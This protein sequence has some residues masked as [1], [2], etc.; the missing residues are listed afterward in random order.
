MFLETIIFLYTDLHVIHELV[1]LRHRDGV[2]IFIIDHTQ[3]HLTLQPYQL[4]YLCQCLFTN[5]KFYVLHT[6]PICMFASFAEK[7]TE[8]LQHYH[9]VLC[10][11]GGVCLLRGT[12]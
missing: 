3:V 11:R 9:I 7:I 5:Q 12:N 6:E 8:I 2:Y 4:L 1:N 10:I